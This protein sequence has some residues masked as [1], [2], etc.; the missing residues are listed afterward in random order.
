[1]PS[2]WWECESCGNKAEFFDVC[3]VKGITHFIWDILLKEEWNQDHLIKNC[4]SCGKDLMRITYEFPRKDKEKLRV[5]HIIGI[6]PFDNNKYLPMIWETHAVGENENDNWF[7]FKYLNGKNIRGLNR[8]AV[9]SRDS[10]KK[11]FDVYSKK[12]GKEILL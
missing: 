1:M 5:I 9:F 12:T 3:Q 6:G 4:K 8:P 11:L 10:L 7:D 2:Y